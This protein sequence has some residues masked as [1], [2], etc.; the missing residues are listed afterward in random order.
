ME[1]LFSE[2]LNMSMTA[3]VVIGM[4]LLVRLGLKKAP[5]IYSYALWAVVLFRLLCPVSI[6][7]PV[8]VLEVTQPKVNQTESVSVIYY[9]VV[10]QVREDSGL[11]RETVLQE[12]ESVQ[13]SQQQ[14]ASEISLLTISA[15]LWMTGLVVMVLASVV[16]YLR[17]HRKLLCAVHW[18]GEIY[19][20]DDIE[21]PFVLGILCPRIYLPSGMA[22]AERRYIVA[23]ERHHIKR[24]DPLWKLLGYGALCIHW[25]NPLV[26]LSFSLAGKDMEM[27]CD[28][29]VIKR[30]GPQIRA[31]Y[32][33]SLLRL[34]TGRNMI[35]GMPLAFGEGDTKGR[36]KN[37]AK[38]KQP[39]LWV[40]VLC[41][42]VCIAIGL[43]C[44]LNPEE[45]QSLEEMTRWEGPSSC[46][47]GDL[48]YYLPEGCTQESVET[49]EVND[50]ERRKIMKEKKGIYPYQVIFTTDAGTV[51]GIRS[52]YAPENFSGLTFDGIREL[53]LMEFDNPTLGWSGG[54]S[55]AAEYELEF[56]TD[57]PGNDPFEVN[58]KHYFF[59]SEDMTMVYDLWFDLLTVENGIYQQILQSCVVGGGSHKPV[60]ATQ[61]FLD[62]ETTLPAGYALLIND[63]NTRYIAADNTIVGGITAYEKPEFDLKYGSPYPVEEWNQEEWLAALGIHWEPGLAI[64]GGS[65]PYGDHERRITSDVPQGQPVTMDEHHT[66]FIREAYVYDVW[67]DM[68]KMEA[69]TS[70]SILAGVSGNRKTVDTQSVEPADLGVE[71]AALERCAAVL[72]LVQSCSQALRCERNN[73]YDNGIMEYWLHEE[74]WMTIQTHSD[75]SVIGFMYKDGTY[76]DN[77]GMMGDRIGIRDENGNFLWKESVPQDTFHIPWL[78]RYQ[79]DEDAVV[80]LGTEERNEEIHIRLCIQ[81]P[82]PGF[83]W[84]NPEYDVTMVF[85]QDHTFLRAELSVNQGHS[86]QSAFTET[87]TIV[88]LFS[89]TVAM[90]MEQKSQN[91]GS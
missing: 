73:G 12:P 8:S 37:M 78:S 82:F 58:T 79:W 11:Y 27:S 6:S 83:E 56:F 48:N 80:Y 25:F 89:E 81:E 86:S 70:D 55:V 32:A 19:L 88:S 46:A 54:G 14:A 77:S 17:L 30:L 76:Y 34:A 51:G 4:V 40:S 61:M 36:V 90:Q 16:N 5:K 69:D 39:K 29:A 60:A 9:D 31:D 57:L 13:E 1:G 59:L 45:E 63:S 53:G 20:A 2:I 24:L 3:S 71:K 49:M 64:M 10:E 67:F 26:W 72:E 15:W 44:A 33:Q 87:E 38:W 43:A 85:A 23:H 91:I 62:F 75:D 68:L 42:V 7:A 21:T 65:S 22:P 28:E 35:S 52:Y 66:Y 41:V 18:R 74:N 50:R 47:V 84:G